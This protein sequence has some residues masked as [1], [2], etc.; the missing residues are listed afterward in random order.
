MS[1]ATVASKT[2]SP[3]RGY[4]LSVYV[5]CGS[6]WC[7]INKPFASGIIS[8]DGERDPGVNRLLDEPTIKIK[9]EKS[10]AAFAISP[11]TLHFDNSDRWFDRTVGRYLLTDT[12]LERWLDSLYRAYVQL[13]LNPTQGTLAN[14]QD[15]EVT[16]GTWIVED[17]ETDIV[18]DVATV[19]LIPKDKILMTT[20]A[21]AV[22]DGGAWYEDKSVGF[23]VK[24]LY[25]HAFGED[26]PDSSY[27]G[28]VMLE[29]WDG[30]NDLN[31]YGRQPSILDGVPLTSTYEIP[32]AVTADDSSSSIL[33][34]ATL[35]TNDY[36]TR[37]YKWVKTTNSSEL[38]HTASGTMRPCTFLLAEG[39]YLYYN[40]LYNDW[41]SNQIYFNR[42]GQMRYI[43]K[44]T[45][46]D[47]VIS[48]NL[49]VWS[50][51]DFFRVGQPI[52]SEFSAVGR[53]CGTPSLNRGEQLCLAHPQRLLALQY[54]GDGDWVSGGLWN[55]Y[56]DLRQTAA[57]TTP[58]GNDSLPKNFDH[59]GWT[60]ITSTDIGGDHAFWSW[61]HHSPFPKG[62]KSS[63]D[64]RYIVW[65]YTDGNNYRYYYV[66]TTNNSINGP[67]NCTIF[68]CPTVQITDFAVT[69]S[70]IVV[71]LLMQR[72]GDDSGDPQRH[73]LYF[74]KGN[75]G[76]VPST[77][78]STAGDDPAM[79]DRW[80]TPIQMEVASD[81]IVGCML[82]R[83]SRTFGLFTL[84]ITGTGAL[85][86][87]DSSPNYVHSSPG[88]LSGFT[89][90]ATDSRVY[91]RDNMTGALWS[92][93]KDLTTCRIEASGASVGYGLDTWDAY[94]KLAVTTEGKVF[95]FSAPTSHLMNYPQNANYEPRVSP[96]GDWELWCL[97]DQIE[98]RVPIADFSEMKIWDALVY[99]LQACGPDWVMGHDADGIFYFRE[100]SALV[101][102][103]Y[104]DPKE[105]VANWL[106][107]EIPLE[108]MKKKISSRDD[109]WNEVKIVPWEKAKPEITGSIELVPRPQKNDG[110]N[111]VEPSPRIAVAPMADTKKA[112]RIVLFCNRDGTVGLVALG[113]AWNPTTLFSWSE[114]AED[115]VTEISTQTA[116]S[117]ATIKVRGM[118]GTWPY[119]EESRRIGE[120]E[121][122]VGDWVVVGD[123]TQTRTIAAF[124]STT[125]EIILDAAPGGSSDWILQGTTV[126]IQNRMSGSHVNS[127]D[128]VTTTAVALTTGTLVFGVTSA[129]AIHTGDVIKIESELMYVEE[130]DGDELTVTRG[131]LDTKIVA[132]AFQRPVG[133]YIHPMVDG[134]Y[135]IGDTGIS[136]DFSAS[137]DIYPDERRYMV[138][139]RIVIESTG[140]RARRSPYHVVI[141]EGMRSIELFKKKSKKIDDNPFIS[142]RVAEHLAPLW[143]ADWELPH[144]LLTILSGLDE[145]LQP[146][147]KISV[148]S[149]RAFPDES[150]NRVRCW[151]RG[152]TYDLK[153]SSTTVD[154]VS[155][156]G[157]E[158]QEAA[159]GGGGMPI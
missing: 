28:P 120:S 61:E 159:K 98:V 148:V 80:M 139:D 156:N 71:G 5:L 2:F 45:F 104:I 78:L 87:F 96:V 158:V 43:N 29:T 24:R 126:K 13:R 144:Y 131:Y 7:D 133:V 25:E 32:T 106:A 12:G 55:M 84:T 18:T 151:V 118:S 52:T 73:R 94:H 138:G 36:L 135:R 31:S 21:E 3:S 152:I 81:R 88:P 83:R 41:A 100:R 115:V 77:N 145:E 46:A 42:K 128:G 60:G 132:H 72:N 143:R 38:M 66:D 30:Q 6:T 39:S 147:A 4:R 124:T 48:S 129:A 70:E 9:G 34:Y 111:E 91:F 16:L 130:M 99:L 112:K 26:L 146:T 15:E 54:Q 65:F 122:K 141:S 74:Y 53:I 76:S 121:I 127:E 27:P 14:A 157:I 64:G 142:S 58:P 95:G 105:D 69:N 8:T 22:K 116:S 149:T 47:T 17:V 51:C 1:D 85:T 37:I 110:S 50:C 103:A 140:T 86:A 44:T 123:D 20:S 79:D 155:L 153:K 35:S 59:C 119:A 67:V 90:N 137:T 89:W 107:S 97:E 154:A 75:I 134:V 19:K 92:M 102:R 93:A 108:G 11:I 150:A 57:T 10:T 125:G 109:I 82:D 62:M 113:T 40:L 136:V 101:E 63:P 114:D 49:S 117:S 68:E 56:K 23:L 33:Y